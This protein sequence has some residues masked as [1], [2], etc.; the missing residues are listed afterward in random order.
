[1]RW[2]ELEKRT[3]TLVSRILASA[4]LDPPPQVICRV[5]R[6]AASTP[7]RLAL[8][9]EALEAILGRILDEAVKHAFGDAPARPRVVL[10]WSLDGQSAALELELHGGRGFDAAGR[11]AFDSGRGG[12]ARFLADTSSGALGWCSQ[13]TIQTRDGEALWTRRVHEADGTFERGEGGGEWAT[14]LRLIMPVVVEERS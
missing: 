13:I 4:K 6:T 9:E 7:P 8:A 5:K 3:R 12:L 2:D 14:R 1:M 11:E 10:T